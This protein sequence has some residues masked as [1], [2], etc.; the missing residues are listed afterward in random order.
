MNRMTVVYHMATPRS[1]GK[2][3]VS[4]IGKVCRDGVVF[5][6]MTHSVTLT[7]EEARQMAEA[8]RDT[9]GRFSKED[10]DSTVEVWCEEHEAFLWFEER[11][12]SQITWTR[13]GGAEIC[14]EINCCESGGDGWSWDFA[15]ALE[16]AASEAEAGE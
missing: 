13:K 2:V 16:E 12:A 8:M 3:V 1:D 10:G 7:S 4:R 9:N 14:E 11:E 5:S 15:Q 6:T